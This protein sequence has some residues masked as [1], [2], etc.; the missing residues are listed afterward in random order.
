MG[1]SQPAISKVQTLGNQSAVHQGHREYVSPH[2]GPTR[3][4]PFG[5]RSN[6]PLSFWPDVTQRDNLRPSYNKGSVSYRTNTSPS[7]T[8]SSSDL[9]DTSDYRPN[10]GSAPVRVSQHGAAQQ[11]VAASPRMSSVMGGSGEALNRVG[12]VVGTTVGN[13]TQPREQDG[14]RS[15]ASLPHRYNMQQNQQ[16][17]SEQRQTGQEKIRSSLDVTMQGE[18]LQRPHD[19]QQVQ[20]SSRSSQNQA[21]LSHNNIQLTAQWSAFVHSRKPNETRQD[22]FPA[23]PADATPTQA[24]AWAIAS[25]CA[26]P[27]TAAV[28]HEKLRPQTQGGAVR[29]L[30]YQNLSRN[31]GLERGNASPRSSKMQTTPQGINIWN[32]VRPSAD[33]TPMEAVGINTLKAP[34]AFQKWDQQNQSEEH[35]TRTSGQHA[36]QHMKEATPSAMFGDQ[37]T[38]GNVQRAAFYGRPSTAALR[39]PADSGL[40]ASKEPSA[41][42]AV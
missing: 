7:S 29:L 4:M 17:L 3:S 26:T 12:R 6:G 39:G 33:V 32:G 22:V 5:S 42:D 23:F 37:P 28:Q 16:T 2:T 1:N 38:R 35:D 25:L 10:L 21:P 36:Q 34:N 18:A 30:T 41:G 19:S 13:Q 8:G 27:S 14:Y 20:Q 24:R 9:G 15:G 40:G 31:G 11:L